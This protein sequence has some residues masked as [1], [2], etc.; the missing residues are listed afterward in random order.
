MLLRL[1]PDQVSNLI[2]ALQRAGSSEIGGQIFGEQL[3]DS[4]FRATTI[5]IQK[6][7]GTIARFFVD[8]VQAARDAISFYDRTQHHYTRFNYI[9]EWHSH[10][11]FEVRPSTT[12]I[13]TMRELV[14][15][16]DFRGNFAVLMIVRLDQGELTHGGWVFDAKGRD[17]FVAI[18]VER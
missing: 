18:E 10:P 6:R 7:R 8:L 2:T 12:D 4:D 15:D 11:L 13:T 9:G 3:S 17:R 16:P 5:T 14:S 1:P